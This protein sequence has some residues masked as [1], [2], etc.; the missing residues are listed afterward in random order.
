MWGDIR[1]TLLHFHMLW[2]IGILT[3]IELYN[4]YWAPIYFYFL[5]VVEMEGEDEEERRIC[6]NVFN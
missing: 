2:L 5:H 4:Q 6:N 3:Y 1:D